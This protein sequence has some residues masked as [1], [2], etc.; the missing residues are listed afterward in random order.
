MKEDEIAT[1]EK[2]IHQETNQSANQITPILGFGSVNQIFEIITPEQ[3]FVVRL[4]KEDKTKYE[5]PKEKWCLEAVAKLGII[6]PKVFGLG[7]MDGYSYMLQNKVDGLNG[8]LC[9][10]NIKLKIWES[11]GQYA[12][13]YSKIQCYGYGYKINA[14]RIPEFS[15]SWVKHISYNLSEL[16]A[17][18][19]LLEKKILSK[20]EQSRV[21]RHIVSLREEKFTF[22]LVHGDLSER[23]VLVQGE[24]VFLLDWGTAG[25]GVVPHGE[26]ACLLENA[27]ITTTKLD[28]YL[29]G[30]GL[31]KIYFQKNELL[32]RKLML[33]SSLDTYR[34]ALGNPGVSLEHYEMKVQKAYF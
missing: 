9:S 7:Y 5:F 16:K 31:D 32:I 3:N 2:I 1:V 33:L 8:T 20:K 30:L 28:Q 14:L 26:T 29:K 34:W 27:E 13:L 25:I 15:S 11:L 6:S 4:N 22:G 17:D 24:K 18:D 10:E 19:T 23:N 21:K 12:K